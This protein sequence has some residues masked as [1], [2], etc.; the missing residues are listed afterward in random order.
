MSGFAIPSL[1]TDTTLASINRILGRTLA[2]ILVPVCTFLLS[3]IF[4]K[5]Y[6]P[7]TISGTQSSDITKQL[8]VR[9]QTNNKSATW[10]WFRLREPPKP[11]PIKIARIK[12]TLFGIVGVGDSGTAMIALDGAAAKI[13]KVGDEIKEGVFLSRLGSDYVILLRGETEEKLAIKK[14]DNLFVSREETVSEQTSYQEE[15]PVKYYTPGSVG[16]LVS[17]IK[18]DPLKIGEMV[19]FE[20]VD[21]GRYGSGVKVEPVTTAEY[22]LLTKLN[23]N[24]GDIVL[25]F[26]R[27]RVTD[28]IEDPVSYQKILSGD[29]F[30]IQFLREGKLES[31]L[32]KME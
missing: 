19:K 24:A 14:A 3:D 5:I 8:A 10:D 2:W 17:K 30:K 12:G 22:D 26:D 18:E 9:E 31:T 25:G 27:N 21:A 4:W 20:T 28:I 11:K 29:E 7:D 16:Y 13:Y 32:V 15:P 23:L 6:Y 1:V